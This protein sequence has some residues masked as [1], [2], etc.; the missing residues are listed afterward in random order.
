MRRRFRTESADRAEGA[1]FSEAQAE[2]IT[3]LQKLAVAST[4]DRAK[5]DFELDSL[6]TNQSLDLR[7]KD[8]ELKIVETK[9][10]LI[11]WV[12]SGGLLQSALIAGC[13]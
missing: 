9:S 8:V 11:R 2:I 10:E 5:H 3:K 12:V 4:L 13:C 7:I 1:G 6:V